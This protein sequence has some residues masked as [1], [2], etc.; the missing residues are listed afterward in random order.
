[1]EF[2][3]E[4]LV[5]LDARVFATSLRSAPRGSAA[6]PGGCTY[7]M[8]QVC[9]NMTALSKRDG[10]VRGIAT[11]T[12]FRRLVAKSPARQFSKEVERAC[13][14]FQFALSTRAGIDCVGHVMRALTDANPT[15][16]VLSVDGIGAYDHV[17][18]GAMLSKLLS[19]PALHG[20][21]PFVRAMYSE[22]SHYTWR[23]DSGKIYT[24][25]CSVREGNRGIL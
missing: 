10:G 5:E 23:D 18:R 4:T 15:A 11:G 24:T 16:T 14:P 25:S 21:L 1:M 6:G 22:P 12:S 3:P 2:T 19:E 13:A 20:F 17:F 9:L 8:L 7:E